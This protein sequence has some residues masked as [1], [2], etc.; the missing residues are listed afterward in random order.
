MEA[1]CFQEINILNTLSVDYHEMGTDYK[2]AGEGMG[3]ER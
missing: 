1:V 2:H 3:G